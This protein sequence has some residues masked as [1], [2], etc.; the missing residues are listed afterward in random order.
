MLFQ[1]V[2][3]ALLIGYSWTYGFDLFPTLQNKDVIN[4]YLVGFFRGQ[5]W[6][7]LY[8]TGEE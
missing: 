3:I 6:A 4:K 5:F 1:L 7:V 8:M 2:I